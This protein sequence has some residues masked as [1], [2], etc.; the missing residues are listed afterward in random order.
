LGQFEVGVL[1]SE[2]PV[3][4]SWMPTVKRRRGRSAASSAKMPATIRG[5]N[6][7]D[8]SPY[9]PPDR[10]GIAAGSSSPLATASA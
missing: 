7:F 6:S 4:S 10:R 3:T 9:R 8:D 5:V 1:G 2:R